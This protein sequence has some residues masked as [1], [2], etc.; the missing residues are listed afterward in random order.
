[1][2][3][4]LNA[5]EKVRAEYEEIVA[6]QQ[7]ENCQFSAAKV[8]KLANNFVGKAIHITLIRSRGDLSCYDRL[9][10]IYGMIPFI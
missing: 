5:V 9:E 1:M 7:K 10:S 8:S 2:P 3:E 4:E 6:C